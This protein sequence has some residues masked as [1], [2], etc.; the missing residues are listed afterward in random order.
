MFTRGYDH[1]APLLGVSY[2][3]ILLALRRS[4]PSDF[5]GKCPAGNPPPESVFFF[6]KFIKNVAIYDSHKSGAYQKYQKYQKYQAS[7]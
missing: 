6:K 7:S 4:D 2:G 5:G 1:S 3:V